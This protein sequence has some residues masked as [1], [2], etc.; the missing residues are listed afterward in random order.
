[1]SPCDHPVSRHRYHQLRGSRISAATDPLSVATVEATSRLPITNDT[2]PHLSYCALDSTGPISPYL[3]A[4]TVT[5]MHTRNDL[6]K[7]QLL[8]SQPTARNA[9][10]MSPHPSPRNCNHLLPLRKQ[11]RK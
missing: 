9:W 8:D 7:G 11:T 10:T 2:S 3:R 6:Y 4:M 5:A 1:M